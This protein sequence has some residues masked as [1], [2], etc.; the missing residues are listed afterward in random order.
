[1]KNLYKPL[2]IAVAALAQ[3]SCQG[4]APVATDSPRIEISAA[5]FSFIPDGGFAIKRLKHDFEEY[6]KKQGLEVDLSVDLL[7][8]YAEPKDK[9]PE[10]ALRYD[11]SEI[12]LAVYG[13]IAKDGTEPFESLEAMVQPP[14]DAVGPAN[15]AMQKAWSKYIVPH[16]ICGNFFAFWSDDEKLKTATTFQATLAALDPAEKGFVEGDLWGSSTLGEFY[17]DAIIDTLG[18]DEARKHLLSLAS[19]DDSSVAAALN[20]E[21][22]N[23]LRALTEKL[24]PNHKKKRKELHEV[25]NVFPRAF[26]DQKSSALL[27]YSEQLY[28][29]ELEYR[30]EPW[31]ENTLP[32]AE[33]RLTIRQFNFGEKSAG[34]PT[35]CDAFLVPKH[36]EISVKK[37]K[38][39]KAFLAFV[40]SKEGYD[41]FEEPREGVAE[42]YL[43]PAYRHIIEAEGAKMPLLKDYVAVI[44]ESFPIL[45]FEIYR[46]IRKAGGAL[47]EKLK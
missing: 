4:D 17:A 31:L 6:A 20:P 32:L 3:L 22:V 26:A 27:G 40:T 30:E 21:A 11:I 43:L 12:D 13:R 24:D 14:T 36:G 44:D 18:V 39:I 28:Y 8:P 47:K 15:S 41:C 42:A 29:V 16:W 10:P 9:N 19:T 1:M 45:D 35:W 23:A 5:V 25:G 7:D 33:N 46:G 2:V 38:A 37:K 34:T